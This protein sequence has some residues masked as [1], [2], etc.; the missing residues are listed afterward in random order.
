LADRGDFVWYQYTVELLGRRIARCR[1]D[2]E[3]TQNDLAE[4]IGIS[5]VAVSHLEA[6]ISTAGER[7]VVLLA[8]CFRQEPHQFVANTDYPA[9][10]T[11]RLPLVAAR[12]TEVEH[13]VAVVSAVVSV[14]DACDDASRRRLVEPIRQ[15]WLPRLNA[16]LS[17]STDQRSRAQLK[18]A[19][20]VLNDR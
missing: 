11:D 2:R 15:H 3:W 6:S 8:G 1:A 14:L 7:T 17:T 10:K 19:I 18:V 5:R 16:L 20:R 9:A 4:R 12:Y 13:V